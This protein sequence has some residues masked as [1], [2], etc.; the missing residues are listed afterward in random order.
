[1]KSSSW[2]LQGKINSDSWTK[3]GLNYS[4]QRQ[5][6]DKFLE[7]KEQNGSQSI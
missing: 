5:R 1:M 2:E 7:E 3:L 4:F 6:N